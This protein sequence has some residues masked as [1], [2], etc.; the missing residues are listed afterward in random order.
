M[1][2]GQP[3]SVSWNKAPI[4]GLRPDLYY[5]CDSCGFVDLGRLLWREDGSVVYNSCWS[6]PAQS[7]SGPS[8]IGLVAIF[9]CLRFE[10]SLFVASYDSQGHGGGIRSRLHTGR[11]GAGLGSSLDSLG[12]DPAENT[13]SIVIA[14]QYFDCCLRI[15]CR[16]HLFTESLPRIE[17]L[18][19]LRYSGFQASCHT[20]MYILYAWEWHWGS[21]FGCCGFVKSLR[22]FWGPWSYEDVGVGSNCGKG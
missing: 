11:C 17:L 5:L 4:W 18:L 13:V 12:S 10:I 16:W 6:S 2:D 20:H 14:Q 15:R 7:F 9:Y 1:T 19:W 8:S 21:C 3:A 22:S